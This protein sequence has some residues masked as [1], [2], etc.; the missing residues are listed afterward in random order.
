M[1]IVIKMFDDLQD[2]QVVGDVRSYHRYN[3]GDVYP[4]EGCKP[5]SE[6][7][8]SLLSGDN[9]LHTPLIAIYKP[10][11]TDSVKEESAKAEPEAAKKT[12][13]KSPARAK[14]KRTTGKKPAA[15]KTT[16]RST[17]KKE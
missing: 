3:P 5:T 6:R 8:R 9:A 14:P 4:R 11:G 1:F 7:I 16:S 10:P 12:T 15:K 13:A 17:R 2:S